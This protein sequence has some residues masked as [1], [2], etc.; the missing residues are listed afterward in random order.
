MAVVGESVYPRPTMNRAPHWAAPVCHP[1]PLGAALLMAANDHWLKGA[2]LLPGA[3]TGKLSDLCGLFFFP[4]LLLT[5][6]RGV[7]AL[8]GRPVHLSPVAT[9]LAV[10]LT[11]ALFALAN[12]SPGFNQWIAG[13]WGHKVM[14]PSDLAALVAL[15]PAWLWLRRCDA[16]SSRTLARPA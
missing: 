16:R 14:D 2:D 5:L 15:A 6:W 9:A 8:R 12:V 1:L 3:L 10:G 13:W 11:G 4:A 7:L